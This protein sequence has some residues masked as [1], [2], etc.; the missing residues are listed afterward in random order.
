[1]TREGAR[2]NLAP[3]PHLRD[4]ENA[5]DGE[6]TVVG[7]GFTRIY[8]PDGYRAVEDPAK[9]FEG[10]ILAEIDLDE[11]LLTKRLADFVR[12]STSSYHFL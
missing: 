4:D 12:H 9:T 8:R 11:N 5:V 7:N 1:V 3:P 10:F 6:A 2:A